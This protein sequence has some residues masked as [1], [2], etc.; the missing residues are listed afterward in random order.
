MR[1]TA[2]RRIGIPV[3]S[4]V[5]LQALSAPVSAETRSVEEDR[6]DNTFSFEYDAESG[7]IDSQ[8]SSNRAASNTAVYF[9][10]SVLE[11]EDSGSGLMAKLT[12]RLDGDDH[13][14]YDGWIGLH[15]ETESGEVAFHRSKPVSI[16]LRPQPGQRR[17]TLRFRLDLPSN[18]RYTA[19]G[20]FEAHD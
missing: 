8:T 6:T 19:I 4:L 5:M 16:H 3:M 12:L 17:A 15:I 10:V 2:L 14:V 13:T 7:S 9:R 1:A 11:T 18:D 20:Y